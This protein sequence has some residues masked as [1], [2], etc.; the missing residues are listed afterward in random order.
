[1]A[2]IA[3]P[4]VSPRDPRAASTIT[5]R[6]DPP[7]PR[8]TRSNR[9]PTHQSPSHAGNQL[10]L[11]IQSHSPARTVST[12]R[13]PQHQHR[14]VDT[15]SR[16]L[17]HTRT[18]ECDTCGDL[19]GY[20]YLLTCRRVCFLCFTENPAY[21]P[22]AREGVVRKFGLKFKRSSASSSSSSPAL[23]AMQVV[24]GL[25][26]P[27][28]LK[29]ANRLTLFDHDSAREAWITTHGSYASVTHKWHPVSIDWA[30]L[31]VGQ[32]LRTGICPS[33]FGDTTIVAKFA[34]FEWEI[35]YLQN[36]T[37]A[38]DWTTLLGALD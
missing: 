1:M 31:V 25:Y 34:R 22:L 11:S 4:K 36:E 37:I 8:Y 23:P 13:N 26:S 32:N 3:N 5:A 15:L 9:L 33:H 18:A 30:D 12:P 17:R 16:S 21:L 38:Y 6:R 2:D 14:T 27:R 24:P 20:L 35:T 10:Y 28:G 29:L 19:G 7:L